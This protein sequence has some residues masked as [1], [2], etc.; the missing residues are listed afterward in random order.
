M[1]DF[2]IVPAPASPAP[3]DGASDGNPVGTASFGA[4]SF[5]TADLLPFLV[6]VDGWSLDSPSA[7]EE[8][9][10]AGPLARYVTD[11]G[12]EGDLAVLGYSV[13]EEGENDSA[14]PT[15]E[16]SAEPTAEGPA[17]SSAEAPVGAA[18]I[19]RLPAEE[20]GA[21]WVS[22]DVPELLVAV[23]PEHQGEGLGRKLVQTLLGLAKLTG[24]EAV[25]LA[26]DEANGALALF[27]DLGF[28][29]IGRGGHDEV[30]MLRSLTD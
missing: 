14:A 12:R 15:T 7:G 28:A 11:W 13:P 27:E 8:P 5:G 2:R 18:W 4:P 21:G 1:S 6:L 25:S 3:S 22:A 29:S 9:V 23:H 17:T 10:L 19:R 26:V 24:V 20:A 30:L 16:G